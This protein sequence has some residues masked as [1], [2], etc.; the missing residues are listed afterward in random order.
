MDCSNHLCDGGGD[1]GG[2]AAA[3]Q[4]DPKGQLEPPRHRVEVRVVIGVGRCRAR[5][6]IFVSVSAHARDRAEGRFT[7]AYWLCLSGDLARA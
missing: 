6:A 7:A 4:H 1:G 3:P 5:P 2:I